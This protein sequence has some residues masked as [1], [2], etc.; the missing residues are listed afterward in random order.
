MI[1][2]KI[3]SLIKQLRIERKQQAIQCGDQWV[4]SD[5]LFVNWQ[6]KPLSPNIPH[7]WLQRFCEKE[8]LPFHGLHSFRHFTATQAIANGVDLKRVS[9]MLGHSQ[10]STTINIYTHAVQ[11]ANEDALNCIANLI[12]TGKSPEL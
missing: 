12:E 9:K 7:K 2:P 8:G 3:L 1:Q 5:R 11:Q 6:G 10:T 4:S